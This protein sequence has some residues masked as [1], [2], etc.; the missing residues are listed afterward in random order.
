MHAAFRLSEIIDLVVNRIGRLAAWLVLAL[1][2]VI[3]F[4]VVTRRFLVLGSTKLQELE[5]HL[6]GALFLLCLGYAYTQSAHVRIEVLRERFSPRTQAWI[7]LLG[8]L[9]FLIPYCVAV[10][11]F[12]WEYASRAWLWNEGSAALTGLSNRWI[13]KS[14]IL[15]GFGLLGLSALSMAIKAFIFL[16]GPPGLA[17]L[18]GI[19]ELHMTVAHDADDDDEAAGGAH[20]G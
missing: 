17:T 6:H 16:Y 8:C 14:M 2:A 5:W 19:E 12:A 20:A 18:T 9:A 13:I 4:D 3:L 15:A 1:M 7:E 10:G 11:W